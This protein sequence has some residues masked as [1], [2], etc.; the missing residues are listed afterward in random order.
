MKTDSAD[1][2]FFLLKL[3]LSE[4]F[5]FL[6]YF[7]HVV[8]TLDSSL[9]SRNVFSAL[10]LQLD[11]EIQ[12][13]LGERQACQFEKSTLSIIKLNLYFDYSFVFLFLI[14]YNLQRWEHV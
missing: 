14:D 12:T 5:S 11:G 6:S 4:T 8:N 3:F 7:S 10:S 9:Q 13:E 2:S 1:L